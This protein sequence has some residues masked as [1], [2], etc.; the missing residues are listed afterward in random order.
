MKRFRLIGI[1]SGGILLLFLLLLVVLYVNN[2]VKSNQ[3]LENPELPGKI[4]NTGKQNLYCTVKGKGSPAIIIEAD[5]GSSSPEWWHIQDA[6]AKNTTVVTYDRAGYG[7]SGSGKMPR[8]TSQIADELEVLLKKIDVRP[9]YILV[10]H[11]FGALCIQHFASLNQRKVAGVV[12]VE[13]I[14]DRYTEF[15][16]K[17]PSIFFINLID[18]KATISVSKIFAGLGIVR[19]LDVVPYQKTPSGVRDLILENYSRSSM[20]KAMWDEYSGSIK[21]SIA[22]I[23]ELNSFPRVPVVTVHHSGDVYKNEL[24]GFGLSYYEADLVESIWIEQ[25]REIVDNAPN[26][27]IVYA[28]RSKKNIHLNEPEIVIK[29]INDLCRKVR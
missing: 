25:F 21:K 6:L 5:I 20:Y 29:A 19:A 9:P 18:K 2:T 17:L 22:Q 8:T 14:T 10:G 3:W 26:G 1:V 28:V 16:E 7:W 4:V 15:R 11:S 24:M 27:K 12:F 23:K 13:P